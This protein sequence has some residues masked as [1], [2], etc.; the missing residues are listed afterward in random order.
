MWSHVQSVLCVCVCVCVLFPQFCEILV[1]EAMI[2]PQED[3]LKFGYYGSTLAIST[4]VH[5]IID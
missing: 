3:L 4:H 2:H 5:R 1:E